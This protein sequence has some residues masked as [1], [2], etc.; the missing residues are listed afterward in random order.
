VRLVNADLRLVSSPPV[1]KEADVRS[2]ADFR[3]P[4]S[5]AVLAAA[6]RATARELGRQYA[7]ELLATRHP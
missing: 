2:P 4:G 1:P 7:R 3:D 6:A 5:E